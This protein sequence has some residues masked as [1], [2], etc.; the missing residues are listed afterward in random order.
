MGG[1]REGLKGLLYLLVVVVLTCL[2]IF[3]FKREGV[4]LLLRNCSRER[5]STD[6]GIGKDGFDLWGCD[7]K[8]S[9]WDER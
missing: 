6:G 9:R 2:P 1:S 3:L 5:T 4:V 7:S 8:R